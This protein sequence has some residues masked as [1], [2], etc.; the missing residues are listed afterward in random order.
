MIYLK[1]IPFKSIITLGVLWLSVL[2][3]C[4]E[5][6]DE[7]EKIDPPP[8]DTV[9]Q[10]T[11]PSLGYDGPYYPDSVYYGREEYVEYH[12]GDLPIILSAPHGGR[13]TPD[14]IPDRTY[15]TTVTDDNTYELTKT[16]MDTMVARFGGRPHVILC[17]LKRT[18]LDANRDSVEAAQD[19][20]Y[21]LRAW[22]EY[23]HYIGIA[24]KKIETDYGSGLFFD[25]HGHGKNPDGFYDLRNWLGYLLSGSELDLSDAVLNTN[26]FKNESSIR[27]LVDSSS[28]SFIEVL[29]GANSFG[30]I[31]D[32]IGFKSV[33]S[34]NDPGPNGKRYFSG[35]YKTVRHGS[36]NGGMISAIQ[37]EA[38]KPGIRENQT[39]WSKFSSAFV[40]TISIYYTKHLKRNLIN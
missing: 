22:Q 10:D 9:K 29:R 4:D 21:A 24:K 5:P 19:D 34:V 18:K 35:G 31:L 28:S 11:F 25:M 6:K 33:P 16:V 32:S 40:S 12:A 26:S 38:P 17:R 13:L 3:G 7:P 30:A 23:H 2:I 15:G 20:K 36:K 8:V 39:T 37:V 1:M 27:A 14:E